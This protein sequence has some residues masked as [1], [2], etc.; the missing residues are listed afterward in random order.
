MLSSRKVL[1]THSSVPILLFLPSLWR[2]QNSLL[3]STQGL[4][5]ETIPENCRPH[6]PDLASSSLAVLSPSSSQ[7]SPQKGCLNSYYL[8]PPLFTMLDQS[9]LSEIPVLWATPS[10]LPLLSLVAMTPLFWEFLSFL[11][12]PSHAPS[13]ASLPLLF[14]KCGCSLGLWP[15]SSALCTCTA[16]QCDLTHARASVT[17]CC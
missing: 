6:L 10:L 13:L 9:P 4:V 8:L 3:W 14:L 15:W 2:K 17:I 16:S 7:P 11:D 12:T 5:P 1:Y